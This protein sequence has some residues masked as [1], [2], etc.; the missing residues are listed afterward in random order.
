MNHTEVMRPGR[1]EGWGT[2]GRGWSERGHERREGLELCFGVRIHRAKNRPAVVMDRA[3]GDH[4][5]PV[6]GQIRIM[7]R[8]SEEL[9]S[10]HPHK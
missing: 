4:G 3:R 8:S 7:R 5:S 2:E 6:L 10:P 1:A 9:C